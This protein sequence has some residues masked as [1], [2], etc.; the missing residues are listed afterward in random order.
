MSAHAIATGAVSAACTGADE[1]SESTA[2][3]QSRSQDRELSARLAAL[4]RRR[5]NAVPAAL[6]IARTREEAVRV[7][8][9]LAAAGTPTPARYSGGLDACRV[10][11]RGAVHVVVGLVRSRAA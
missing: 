8:E 10:S 1:T 5:P 7:T 3:A 11:R 9:V 2:A 6:A 4:F